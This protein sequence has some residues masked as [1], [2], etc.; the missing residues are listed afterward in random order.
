MLPANPE[1]GVLRYKEH[2][3]AFSSKNAAEEFSQNP[4]EWVQLEIRI[5][6]FSFQNKM[7]CPITWVVAFIIIRKYVL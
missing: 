1:I 3:Y 4:A 7:T 6:N 2:Y 5:L